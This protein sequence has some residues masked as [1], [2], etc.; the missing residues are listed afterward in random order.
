MSS[1]ILKIKECRSA[2]NLIME[3]CIK[4]D[5]TQD[6]MTARIWAQIVF[7]DMPDQITH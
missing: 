3:A 6:D 1:E 7:L 5:I 4:G 2:I